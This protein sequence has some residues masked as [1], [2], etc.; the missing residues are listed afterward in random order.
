MEDHVASLAE[1]YDAVIA[2]E[3]MEHVASVDVFLNACCRGLKPGGSLFITTINKTTQS[4]LAAIVAAEYVLRLLPRGTH[5]W[6]MFVPLEQLQENLNKSKWK[7]PFTC[8]LFSYVLM[9]APHFGL[10]QRSLGSEP[11]S[12]THSDGGHS[13]DNCM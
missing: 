4:Y 2:S 11:S 1:P 12:P 6:N 8:K 10:L 9:S 7:V 13:D 3:V 5:D